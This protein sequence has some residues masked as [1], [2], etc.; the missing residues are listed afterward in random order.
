MD[1]DRRQGPKGVPGD[2][3][4]G[5]GAG[6]TPTGGTRDPDA[7]EPQSGRRGSETPEEAPTTPDSPGSLIEYGVMIQRA[8]RAV[9]R[10]A[11]TLVC[12]Q[13]LP[14]DHHFFLEF[15]TT[16]P[17]VELPASLCREFPD[18][19][20]IVLQ[21]QFWNLWV[22]PDH[23]EVDLRFGGRITRLA[24]PFDALTAFIDPAAGLALRFEPQDEEADPDPRAPEPDAEAAP[25]ASAPVVSIDAFRKRG[26]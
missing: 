24:V 8:L 21:H 9:V 14:G 22:G 16:A 19:M 1:D 13:G 17:G 4:P 7:G 11:L 2:G 23:F 18:T 15:E 25:D 3:V 26:R 10:D 12:E 6:G 5:K 20:R